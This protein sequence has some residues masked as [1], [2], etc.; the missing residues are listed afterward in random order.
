[1]S[2]QP[3]TVCGG[4]WLGVDG[5][6]WG[7]L[8]SRFLG[9]RP[10]EV[11]E[12]RRTASSAM[13]RVAR[14]SLPE[15]TLVDVTTALP[16]IYRRCAGQTRVPRATLDGLVARAQEGSTCAWQFIPS[17]EARTRWDPWAKTASC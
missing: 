16:S 14:A 9:M 10:S 4:D 13:N 7:A 2:F 15:V 11:D 8:S 12:V 1:M 17:L 6:R 5:T 3:N